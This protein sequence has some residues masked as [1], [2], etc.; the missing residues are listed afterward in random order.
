MSAPP[1]RGN[2]RPV[3]LP[4]R[5]T[6][7]VHER[8]GPAGAAT[9]VLLHGLG[10]T[11]LLNWG[12]SIDALAAQFRVLALDQRGHGRGIPVRRRFRLADCADDVV[13]LADALGLR[14]F[15]AVGYSMG[16]P[17]AQLVWHRH[18]ERVRGLVLCATA[19]RF[20]DPQ[21]RQAVR[22]IAPLLTA[23]LRAFPRRAWRRL[24][25]QMLDRAIPD[26]NVRAL[27]LDELGG[28]DPPA[29]IEA[30]MALARFSSHGWLRDVDVPT[31][32]VLTAR[33]TIVPPRRQ[34][35]LATAIPGA[36]IHEVAGDHRVCVA[37]P[38]RFASVLLDACNDVV[39]E[40]VR[41]AA[42]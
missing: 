7:F 35:E 38:D 5:G 19:A 10:A 33:D 22:R 34:R 6:T 39:N 24:G 4:G 9:L 16:G 40:E 42:R 13:A 30:G 3:E 14:R 27:V 23:P 1:P 17:V 29:L 31:A 12:R 28:T 26:P 20:G 36:R 25:K 21:R 2:G 15:V 41:R 37:D 32:I 18:R 11:A 8:S